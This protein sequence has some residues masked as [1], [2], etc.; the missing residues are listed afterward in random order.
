MRKKSWNWKST[1]SLLQR[2]GS[3]I[4]SFISKMVIRSIYIIWK[5][6]SDFHQCADPSIHPW[7][8]SPPFRTATAAGT[9]LPS[10]P[11]LPILLTNN[12]YTTTKKTSSTYLIA[13]VGL[14]TSPFKLVVQGC[15]VRCEKTTPLSIT[16]LVNSR[17][18][19]WIS[20]FV[21]LDVHILH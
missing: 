10:L 18:S 3:I 1:R 6:L 21:A 16:W 19:G 7:H 9:H 5:N 4:G 13:T 17:V 11:T 12:I 8:T 14:H 20:H 2:N 15:I